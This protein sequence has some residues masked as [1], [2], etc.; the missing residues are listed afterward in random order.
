[1]FE[2]QWSIS[3]FLTLGDS[4]TG[5]DG[6]CD[7]VIA[8]DVDRQYKAGKLPKGKRCVQI[9]GAGYRKSTR[10][11]SIAFSD[12]NTRSTVKNRMRR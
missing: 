1:M 8:K 3:L 9:E 4:P 2:S 6:C 7:M 11:L 10:E 12:K 5:D